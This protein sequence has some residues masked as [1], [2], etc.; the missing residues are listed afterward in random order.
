MSVCL[1]TSWKA[2]LG[3]SRETSAPK[4]AVRP[5]DGTSPHDG[6]KQLKCVSYRN[7]LCV[8]LRTS[9][10]IKLNKCVKR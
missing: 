8:E 7:G 10:V 6:R 2:A 9:G 4:V 3:G 5:P 1:R